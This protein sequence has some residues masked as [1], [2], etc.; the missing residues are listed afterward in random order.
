MNV[1]L[2]FWTYAR[3]IRSNGTVKNKTKVTPHPHYINLQFF[4]DFAQPS[5]KLQKALY[6]FLI[7]AFVTNKT[8]KKKN[9]EM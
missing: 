2:A 3:Q 8:S 6:N 4:S 7:F 9:P 5:L 1:W